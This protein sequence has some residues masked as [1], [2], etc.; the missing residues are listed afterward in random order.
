MKT[1]TLRL[2]D[3]DVRAIERLQRHTGEKTASKALLSAARLHPRLV[4][5]RAEAA[6]VRRQRDE[7]RKTLCASLGLDVRAVER[8]L[9]KPKVSE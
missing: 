2:T 3:A 1:L 6:E 5:D 9:L 7:L 4:S 8:L